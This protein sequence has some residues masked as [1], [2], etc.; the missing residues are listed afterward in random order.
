MHF[1]GLATSAVFRSSVF[2]IYFLGL[3]KLVAV[4]S[5]APECGR[6]APKSFIHKVLMNNKIHKLIFRN[7]IL[8]GITI[9]IVTGIIIYL[10]ENNTLDKNVF[11]L[12]TQASSQCSKYYNDFY[13]NSS[14]SALIILEKSIKNSL[15]PDKF[16]L[17]EIYDRNLKKII[18]KNH[19]S[20][21][22]FKHNLNKKFSTFI[23]QGE[24]AHKKILFNE[25][26]YLK[27]MLPIRDMNT[28][29]IIGHFE[30][31]YHVNDAKFTEIKKQIF[32][33]VLQSILI[34]MTTTILLY[35]IILQLTQKLTRRSFEL[36]DSNINTIKSLGGAIA[37]RDSDTNSHNYRVTIY[38]VRI[39]EELCLTN[40]QIQ[41]LI[42]GAFLHDVGK[43]GISDSILLKPEK[44]TCD[45]F[46]IMKQHVVI[47]EDIIK[48]NQWLKDASD[49]V[50]YHHEKFDGSGYMTQLQGENIPINA[51]IFA[52]ADV[53]DAL[54]S[55][56]PYKEAFSFEKS[57]AIL[58]DGNGSH[59]DPKLLEKFEEIAEELYSKISN[60]E[61]E[62]VLSK[63][64]DLL[65]KEYF[66]IAS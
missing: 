62:Q 43:I 34:V 6:S 3:L 16:I 11:K 31:I 23:M 12:A 10:L 38:S 54:T 50:I 5:P 13:H 56:R 28:K 64:L 19:K 36:L 40:L 29:E 51:R 58:K 44:L 17:I 7:L 30:G 22:K 2:Q 47:G 14:D 57:M 42:K 48:Y 24:F 52:I 61:N 33:S 1:K 21:D 4:K 37:K 25:Q 9:S 35:P 49:V 32:L 63:H 66:Y 20:I 39:A 59:F 46:K 18:I 27:I 8:G 65:I 41:A 45:E 26:L 15:T 53:F 55:T 60:L